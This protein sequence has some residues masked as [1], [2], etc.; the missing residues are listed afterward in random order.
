MLKSGAAYLPIDANYPPERIKFML[1]DAKP[2]LLVT[3]TNLADQFPDI[4][5]VLIDA[6]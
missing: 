4:E 1:A 2:M 6:P 5:L 3:T